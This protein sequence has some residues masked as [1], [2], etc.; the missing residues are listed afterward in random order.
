MLNQ[1]ER[2]S[3]GYQILN[4]CFF[5]QVA[6]NVFMFKM[7]VD[8]AQ[9]VNMCQSDEQIFDVVFHLDQ[10]HRLDDFWKLGRLDVRHGQDDVAEV[11]VHEKK[12]QHVG[13]PS[14]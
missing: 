14:S 4:C 11:P 7:P 6:Q 3:K 1:K 12:R 13:L 5:R 2:I 9:G 8:N 10:V